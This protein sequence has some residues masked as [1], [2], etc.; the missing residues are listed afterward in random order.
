MVAL[1]NC[2]KVLGTGACGFIGSHLVDRLVQL[3]IE[4]RGLVHYN[5]RNNWGMLEE[6]A[7]DIRARVEVFP[8]DLTD[9]SLV[10]RAVSDCQV[11]FHLGALI[12]I[13]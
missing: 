7:D 13:P 1:C 6:L 3:G 4:V 9:A 11:V 8:G 5:S 12:A 2:Q 10:R